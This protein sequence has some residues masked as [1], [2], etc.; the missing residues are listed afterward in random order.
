MIIIIAVI[1]IGIIIKF[2]L[3]RDKMIENQVDIH[4]GMKEKYKDLIEGLRQNYSPQ[5]CEIKRDYLHFRLVFGSRTAANF[6]ITEQ[7]NEVKIEWLLQIDGP[8]ENRKLFWTFPQGLVQN[9]MVDKIEIDIEKL[10]KNI[11]L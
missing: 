1:I 4:G 9:K 2:F 11:S 8:F 10:I 6:Y 3:D 5:F 7:F